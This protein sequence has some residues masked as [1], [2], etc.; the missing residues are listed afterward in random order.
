M[1]A[2]KRAK[3]FMSQINDC[4]RNSKR[5]TLSADAEYML[6]LLI[7]ECKCLIIH[8]Q[9]GKNIGYIVVIMEEVHK[10][11]VF[12]RR[13]RVS[14]NFRHGDA[15][16][17]GRFNF[18][19]LFLQS[20]ADVDQVF[21]RGCNAK[22]VIRRLHIFSTGFNRL[23]HKL[24]FIMVVFFNLYR[25]LLV[26]QVA[27]RAVSSK[28]ATMFGE[29]MPDFAYGAVQVVAC[30]FDKISY[31]AWS[32]TFVGHLFVVCRAIIEL[33]GSFFDGALNIVFRKID[34]FCILNCKREPGIC[35]GITTAF[36]GR[37]C[38]FTDM[39]GEGLGSLRI[40]FRLLVLNV[41]PFRVSCHKS[42]FN[43]C[44]FDLIGYKYNGNDNFHLTL[45]R[46]S[47]LFITA[48]CFLH[49]YSS[50]NIQFH[51]NPLCIKI[52]CGTII[53]MQKWRSFMMMRKSL[54]WIA[55]L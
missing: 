34:R 30:G 20:F 32:V 46:R 49:E 45:A 15:D 9:I 5:I 37:N 48:S 44:M 3:R 38:N 1:N 42:F 6:I 40:L 36:P 14:S 27:H 19:P 43:R 7:C 39:L 51:C 16:K 31:S 23:K 22:I 29:K 50:F 54:T 52:H 35:V 47:P 28:V 41:R 55:V 53:L 21:A 26:K 24:L 33:S 8:L 18:V 12:F 17:F 10:Y 25:T 13:F 4:V 2:R 11:K